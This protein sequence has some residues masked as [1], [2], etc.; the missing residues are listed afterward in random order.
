RESRLRAGELSPGDGERLFNP[1]MQDRMDPAKAD[2]RD[3]YHGA[4]PH[5][6]G[7]KLGR[8]ISRQQPDA[9]TNGPVAST[10]SDELATSAEEPL[11]K[12]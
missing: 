1:R 7:V 10:I 4:T 11:I 12:R 9:G 6:G 5:E 3:F 2:W 8:R